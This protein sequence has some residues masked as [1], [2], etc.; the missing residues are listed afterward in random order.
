MSRLTKQ[1]HMME[2]ML[3]LQASI[4]A[5]KEKE[6]LLQTSRNE[7]YTNIFKPITSVLDKLKPTPTPTPAVKKEEEEDDE[8][9][10][11]R[12]IEDEG[13][14]S[15]SDTLQ[16]GRD[17]D[18]DE[19]QH[20]SIYHTVLG[21]IKSDVRDD[22]VFGLNVN[23]HR[24]GDYHYRVL[25]NTLI[26]YNNVQEFQYHIKDVNLW[27][28]LIAQ[29]PNK[30]KL[31]IKSRGRYLDFVK[32]YK[33]IVDDLELVKSAF[34]NYAASSIR[35]RAKYK[36]IMSMDKKGSGF[37]FSVRPPPF[38]IG[39]HIKPSTVVI[40]S[41]KKGLLRALVKA[42]AELRAGN[43]SMRNIVV[44]LA[45]EAERRKILPRNLLSTDEKTWV[46]A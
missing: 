3:Y 43:T 36:I 9:G 16:A 14:D 24:I 17:T 11:E 10:G 42:V 18:E 20:G 32:E 26:V 4:R 29:T 41:D 5:K 35:I 1:I 44:P 27:R 15:G 21:E 40:P 22:G 37:M 34:Q 2:E 8:G 38:A 23:D 33:N 45:Q 19:E 30:A 6:R 28:L 39:K 13:S 46:F 7:K 12:E 25:Y 31:K